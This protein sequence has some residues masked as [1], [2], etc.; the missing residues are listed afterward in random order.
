[1]KKPCRPCSDMI[2][3]SQE[4]RRALRNRSGPSICS[5]RQQPSNLQRPPRPSLPSGTN[6]NSEA[7]PPRLPGNP[8]RNHDHTHWLRRPR[9]AWPTPTR[10]AQ[11]RRTTK[12]H[13]RSA[14]AWR[15]NTDKPQGTRRNATR[16][17]K[18]VTDSSSDKTPNAI[19]RQDIKLQFRTTSKAPSAGI[20]TTAPR[21]HTTHARTHAMRRHHNEAAP[22]DDRSP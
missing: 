12:Q 11:Q 9:S 18:N 16:A 8:L 21:L 10:V 1:M 15:R 22:I 17:K 5:H 13:Q 19:A 20:A 3:Y 14:D 2:R 7:A 6:R 4:V